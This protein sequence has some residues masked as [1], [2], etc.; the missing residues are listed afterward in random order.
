MLL[1]VYGERALVDYDFS[2]ASLIV[3]VGQISLEIGKVEVLIQ[4]MLRKN[5]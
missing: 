2:K 3:S 1:N 5:S 4:V